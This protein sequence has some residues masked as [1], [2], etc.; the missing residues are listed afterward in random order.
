MHLNFTVRTFWLN[1]QLQ[2]RVKVKTNNILCDKNMY[3]LPYDCP[4]KGR[5]RIKSHFQ[6]IFV[7]LWKKIFSTI[8]NDVYNQNKGFK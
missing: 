3:Y 2:L 4:A 6:P 5:M 1:L 8:L 7:F